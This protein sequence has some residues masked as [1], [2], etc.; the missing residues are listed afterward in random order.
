MIVS[1]KNLLSCIVC[2]VL[3]NAS[4]GFI[5]LTFWDTDILKVFMPF[6]YSW[7]RHANLINVIFHS[8]LNNVFLQTKP[9]YVQHIMLKKNSLKGGMAA[10][11]LFIIRK[12]IISPHH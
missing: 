10:L 5:T 1:N 2:I 6:P 12:I 4:R 3:V 8:K 9:L 11:N 7:F